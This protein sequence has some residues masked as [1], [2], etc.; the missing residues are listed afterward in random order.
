MSKANLIPPALLAKYSTGAPTLSLAWILKRKDGFVLG[1]TSHVA[2]VTIPSLFVAPGTNVVC[3]AASGFLATDIAMTDTLSQNNLDVQG[4][5]DSASITESAIRAGLWANADLEIVEFDYNDYATTGLN[6]KFCGTIGNISSDG[7][8]AYCEQRG[9]TQPLEANLEGV[10]SYECDA[11]LGDARCGVDLTPFLRTST[12]TTNTNDR[13]FTD[14]ARLEAD[15]WWMKGTMKM[16]SGPSSGLVQEIKRSTAT[17]L[18][19]VV[20][21]FFFGVN[22][23]DQY[24]V[25]PG[26]NKLFLMPDGTYTGDC[27]V[28][29]FNGRRFRGK[30]RVPGQAKINQYGGQDAPANAAA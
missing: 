14:S 26:C 8:R 5:L 24:R 12:I 19:E 28:K 15:G 30:P 22:V 2:D 10:V 25:S 20:E 13:V 18:L 6:P 17:G 23:G 7:L 1:L 3:S 27:I 16:L 11:K 4:V 9:L 29:F 21:P